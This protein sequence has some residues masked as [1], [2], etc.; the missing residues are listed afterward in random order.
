MTHEIEVHEI[1]K[2][3]FVY[4]RVQRYDRKNADDTAPSNITR[5]RE[6]REHDSKKR[7]DRLMLSL[8]HI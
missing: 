6:V 5:R 7:R 4:P 2:Y 8:I 3:S 1:Q